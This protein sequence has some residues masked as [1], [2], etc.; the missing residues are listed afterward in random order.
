MPLDR[1]VDLLASALGP[2]RIDG[3]PL[4]LPLAVP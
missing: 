4:R 3:G 2:A 1:V